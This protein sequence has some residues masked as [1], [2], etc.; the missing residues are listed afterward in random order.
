MTSFLLALELYGRFWFATK[1]SR[2]RI[3]LIYLMEAL[4]VYERWGASAKV[5]QL[6]AECMQYMRKDP[7]SGAL[8]A[9][10]SQRAVVVSVL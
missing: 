6:K 10:E 3:G 2:E 1:K 8:F 7:S 9:F 5:D 4:V